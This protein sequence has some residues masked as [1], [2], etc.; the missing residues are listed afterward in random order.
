MSDIKIGDTVRLKSGGPTMT[1]TSIGE[2]GMMGSGP[3]HAYVTWFTKDGKLE[4]DSFP[5]DALEPAVA[6]Q[7]QVGS[8]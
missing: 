7:A 3:K 8:L 5:L 4:S 1:V 2:S 6:P